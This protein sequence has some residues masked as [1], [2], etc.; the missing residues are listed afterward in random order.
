[1]RRDEEEYEYSMCAED[2]I[3]LYYPD[4]LTPSHPLFE[5]YMI[6]LQLALIACKMQIMWPSDKRRALNTVRF[7]KDKLARLR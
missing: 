7:L 5:R 4:H 6:E 1:M 3:Q 2:A